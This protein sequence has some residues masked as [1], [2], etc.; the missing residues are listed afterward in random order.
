[1]DESL[2]ATERHGTPH[3]LLRARRRAGHSERDAWDGLVHHI[4]GFR[5]TRTLG[6]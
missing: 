5:P 2:R 6:P 3:D 4:Y 1:M